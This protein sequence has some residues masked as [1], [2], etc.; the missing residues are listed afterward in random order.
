MPAP[1]SAAI[2][3]GPFPFTTLDQLGLKLESEQG[4][5]DT[6][7]ID[8][9]ERPFADDAAAGRHEVQ[10]T[11]AP[12]VTQA[13]HDFG[14]STRGGPGT[15]STLDV[16]DFCCP[17]YLALMIEHIRPGWTQQTEL[18]GTV[19]ISLTKERDGPITRTSV[20]RTSGYETL[21]LAARHAVAITR[22]LPP[23]PQAFSNPTLTV[24]LNFQYRS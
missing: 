12:P 11:I 18:A 16:A 6:L 3:I 13:P 7:V 17:Q 10:A 24:H 8:R 15:G 22:Q 14:L 4:T 9:A 20:E 5:V 23:L 2:G 19:V 1:G 21:D